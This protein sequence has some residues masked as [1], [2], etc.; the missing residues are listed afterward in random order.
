[1]AKLVTTDL[2]SLTSNEANAV[3]AINANFAATEVA[4]EKT[5]TRD[6]TSPNEM[7]S[8]LDMNNFDILNC[9][10]GNFANLQVGGEEVSSQDLFNTIA[11]AG[12]SS[13]VADSPTDTLT[14]AAGTNITITTNAA[15]DTVTINST[16]GGGAGL[17]DG[18]YGDI[19]V[20]GTGT[21][22]A[23]D[24][25]VI[26]NADVNASAAIDATK[27]ADGS[28]SNAEL[29]YINTLS[30]NAQTQIDGK[31][32]LDSDLTAIASLTATTDNFLQSKSSTWASRTPTQV[33]ADLIN[34][35]GD[36]GAGGT[37]GLVP[38]PA[39]GDA[40]ANK[41]LKADGTWAAGGAG[42]SDLDGLSDVVI[43][44]AAQG[45]ILYRNATQFVNLPAGVSGRY[46]QT[47]GAGA[48]PV[49][50]A[51]AAAV[52]LDD[53]SDVVV[54]SAATNQTLRH[55]GTN[56]IN[57]SGVPNAQSGTTYTLALADAYKTV[58]FDNASA[59]TITIPTN[60]VI[61]FPIGTRI[62]LQRRG[63]GLPSLSYAGV[64]L[65]L[66]T[67]IKPNRFMGVQAVKSVDQTAAN[68]SASPVITFDT[69]NWDTDGFHDTGS[70]TERLTIPSG[71][72]IKKV[73]V[74]SSISL[75]AVAASTITSALS[76]IKTGGAGYVQAYAMAKSDLVNPGMHAYHEA[77]VADTNY[78]H[79]TL[80]CADTSITVTAL[81]SAFRLHV[82][83]IDPVGSIAYRY[84]RIMI[85]KVG[86]DE[87]DIYGPA[88]G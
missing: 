42:A 71:F 2:T 82:L 58:S 10:V 15:T 54:S 6:G 27:L 45:D 76:I 8:D 81:L 7:E 34:M 30:S 14:L 48:D 53:L 61:P 4:M 51:G 32:P 66:P 86:T 62:E 67:G 19:V 40:A 57:V 21:A 77:I 88:L 69:D 9:N 43:T 35:V 11:V 18:D 41:F 85:E 80:Y 84:G 60:A 29:Q 50:A 1:M 24:A 63:A 13:I 37:K 74:S 73:S 38:A 28:V 56:F 64:T 33:T 36:S 59:Q 3:S 55:N 22:M 79:C 49:W 5:L 83:E 44:G 26:V 12:Q 20:S 46:L 52:A 65:N 17:V 16:G 75:A 39:A 72:G 78:F 68:Y 31:Q 25:G 70:S 47:Q 23:I 87:W